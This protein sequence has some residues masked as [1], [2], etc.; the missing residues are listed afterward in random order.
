MQND[1]LLI[2][3]LINE[4]NYK[5]AEKLLA[6]ALR[7]NSESMKEDL[8]LLR[9]RLRLLTGHPGDALADFVEL[10]KINKELLQVSFFVELLA[11]A[12]LAYYTNVKLG[13]SESD[14]L[15]IALNMYSRLTTDFPDYHNYGWA[16]FQ[17]ARISLLQNDTH[18]AYD[19]LYIAINQPSQVNNLSALCYERLA[20]IELYDRR[21]F[22]QALGHINHALELYYANKFDDLTWEIHAHLMRARLLKLMGTR[23]DVHEVLDNVIHAVGKHQMESPQLLSDTLL[24]CGEIASSITGLEAETISYLSQFIKSTKRPLDVDVTWSRVYEL[25]GYSYFALKHYQDAISMLKSS[26]ELN[27]DHPWMANIVL[28]IAYCHYNQTE[29]DKTIDAINGLRQHNLDRDLVADKYMLYGILGNALFATKQYQKAAEAY[30]SALI[31][32]P[33]NSAQFR[34]FESFQTLAIEL[35]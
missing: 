21:N 7:D 28:L 17:L 23:Q 25:L 14:T 10:S 1:L 11:D 29:F 19:Y 13:F 24:A 32:T 5:Q 8:I 9:G 2:Q 26:L 31:G 18:S 12:H 16:F 20:F 30:E 27:P 33:I 15:K 34:D 4:Q 3:S 35:A 6:I 22:T